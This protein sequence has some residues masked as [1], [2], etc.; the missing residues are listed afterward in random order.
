MMILPSLVQ[1]HGNENQT[2][3]GSSNQFMIAAVG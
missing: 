1:A 2:S 3:A